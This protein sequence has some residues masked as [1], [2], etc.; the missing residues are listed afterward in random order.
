M[1]HGTR[2][3]RTDP[4]ADPGGRVIIESFTVCQTPSDYDNPVACR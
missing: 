2:V 3:A 1:P 4:Q